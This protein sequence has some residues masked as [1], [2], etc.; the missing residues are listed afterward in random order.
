MTILNG[1]KQKMLCLPCFVGYIIFNKPHYL[2]IET[3]FARFAE[4]DYDGV[5]C[6]SYLF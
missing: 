2:V 1:L 6:P 4:K 5:R 3:L